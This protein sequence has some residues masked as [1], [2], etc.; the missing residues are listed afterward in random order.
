MSEISILQPEEWIQPALRVM[1]AVAAKDEG[2]LL[3]G[4]LLDVAY[5]QSSDSS[6][7]LA[8]IDTI[9]QIA[10]QKFKEPPAV[11]LDRAWHTLVLVLVDRDVSEDWSMW[12]DKIVPQ[13]QAS[14]GGHKVVAFVAD[15]ATQ[16][17]LVS[18]QCKLASVQLNLINRFGEKALRPA[19][20]GLI[21]INEGRRLLA[22]DCDPVYGSHL[23]L[24]ISHA[25]AD[26]LPLA[27]AIKN[28]ISTIPHIDTFYD[29]SDLL[30]SGDWPSGLEGNI[31]QSTVL[32][33][34]T[35]R[36]DDRS[37][38]RDE[39]HWADR[40]A[41][42][43]LVID[44]RQ[45]L[46]LEESHLPI[47]D[48]PTVKLPD[49][50]VYRALHAALWV[51]LRGLCVARSVRYLQETGTLGGARVRV[52]HRSPT[53]GAIR[54]ICKELGVDH[55]GDQTII[56]YPEPALEGEIG[57]PFHVFAE[58]HLPGVRLATVEQ[59]LLE[60]AVQL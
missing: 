27:L 43:V 58:K 12:F 41:C 18:R 34:R 30:L 55:S 4:Q 32:I 17:E 25:K 21:A 45:A 51:G 48:L 22:Q 15:E 40:H 5:G 7:Y 53:F 1:I 31:A 10:Y 50:N 3:A 26:G 24:F 16:N 46:V 54:R 49:G 11:D 39:A 29:D 42:P 37:F 44:A 56:V 60:A 57:E 35:D 59:L 20:I 33:I 8:A 6:G 52:L 28:Q 38:C 19:V 36:F 47:G 23:K 2:L 9:G 14:G 13:V